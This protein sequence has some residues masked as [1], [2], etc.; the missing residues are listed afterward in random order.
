MKKLEEALGIGDASD[1]EKQGKKRPRSPS[2][3]VNSS[4]EASTSDRATGANSYTSP[5]K[6]AKIFRNKIDSRTLCQ[7]SAM[8][9]G[10]PSEVRKLV[11][12][13]SVTQI[14]KMCEL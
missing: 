5:T 10:T 6:I 7:L 14:C 2:S 1:V 13:A 3:S 8:L 11:P 9:R 4:S 12:D